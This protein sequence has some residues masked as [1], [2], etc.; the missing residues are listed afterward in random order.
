MFKSYSKF[1]EH[2]ITKALL[3]MFGETLLIVIGIYLALQIDTWAENRAAEDSLKSNLKYVI[4][5]IDNNETTLSAASEI[6]AQS[7]ARCTNLID[8]FKLEK[9]MPSEKIIKSLSGVLKTNKIV[10]HQS[11]F[12]RIKTSSLYESDD[13]FEVRDKIRAYNGII[14]DMRFTENFINNYITDLSLD[15]SKNGALLMVFDY[16][17]MSM[18]IAQYDGEI[19]HFDIQDILDENKALQAVL[20]KYE[21]DASD[22]IDHYKA[23]DKAGDELKVAIEVYLKN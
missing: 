8:S 17:R 6:K 9:S 12:E 11:G 16:L 1:K 14:E 19:P 21:F 10:F 23:L 18:D 4:E 13:F 2:R 7:I 15:M 5:D 3:W 20:H 22:L